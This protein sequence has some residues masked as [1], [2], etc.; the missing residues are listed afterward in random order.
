MIFQ[1]KRL[2][3]S[4]NMWTEEQIKKAANHYANNNIGYELNPIAIQSFI[5]GVHYILNN[6]QKEQY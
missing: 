2:R 3:N 6:T 4:K 1:T 5:A